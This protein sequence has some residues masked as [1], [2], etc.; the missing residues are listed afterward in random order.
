M[1]QPP[2][3]LSG[4]AIDVPV[5]ESGMDIGFTLNT[6]RKQQL[7]R[8]RKYPQSNLRIDNLQINAALLPPQ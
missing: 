5:A 8:G 6:N 3:T 1:K 2:H 7:T 4:D